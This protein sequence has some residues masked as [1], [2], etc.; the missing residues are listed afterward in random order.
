MA[1][2]GLR[3]VGKGMCSVHVTEGFCSIG[4]ARSSFWRPHAIGETPCNATS[5]QVWRPPG[6][7]AKASGEGMLLAWRRTST[8]SM[9]PAGL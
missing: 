7:G 5:L 9:R 1:S 6:R 3:G 8:R 4:L 2:K